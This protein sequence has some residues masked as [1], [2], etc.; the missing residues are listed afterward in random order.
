MGNCTC[1]TKAYKLL[2]KL[3]KTESTTPD[4]IFFIY[5]LFCMSQILCTLNVVLPKWQDQCNI[6]SSSRMCMELEQATEKRKTFKVTM[7]GKGK[8]SRN[9]HSTSRIHSSFFSPMPLHFA[10]RGEEKC[11][12]LPDMWH[13]PP[14]LCDSIDA[15]WMAQHCCMGV[16]K[17]SIVLCEL[18][19][20]SDEKWAQNLC[21]I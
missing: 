21:K 19:H 18:W 16:R 7:Q 13:T 3:E 9:A 8:G 2:I 1:N 11:R 20:V 15:L 14:V 6:N 10:I 17:K 4:T 12:E 5:F